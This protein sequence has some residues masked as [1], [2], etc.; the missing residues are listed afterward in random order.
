M[1]LFPA[2]RGG[3]LDQKKDESTLRGTQNL[4]S[5]LPGQYPSCKVEDSHS[6]LLS[7]S[8]PTNL[9]FSPAHWSDLQEVCCIFSLTPYS[10]WTAEPPV[11]SGTC[12]SNFFRTTRSGRHVPGHQRNG[13]FHLLLLRN[14]KSTISKPLQGRGIAKES[15]SYLREASSCTHA[16]RESEKCL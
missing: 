1:S 12:V 9:V 4:V 6:L 15:C 13:L 5:A 11:K 16:E 10:S 8:S 2:H 7:F 14:K 3:S